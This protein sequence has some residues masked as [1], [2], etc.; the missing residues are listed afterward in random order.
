MSGILPDRGIGGT[1]CDMGYYDWCSG[2][3][4]KGFGP[5]VSP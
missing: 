3:L 1:L 4:E 2:T 5:L